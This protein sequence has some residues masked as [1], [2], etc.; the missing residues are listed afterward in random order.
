MGDGLHQA[1]LL[2]G[3]IVHPVRFAGR[4][5]HMG[6][7]ALDE[8]VKLVVFIDLEA[9]GVVNGAG[10]TIAITVLAVDGLI[11]NREQFAQSGLATRVANGERLYAV[12]E[13]LEHASHDG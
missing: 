8:A 6:A 1:A 2:V 4:D 9:L 7:P 12:D 11:D 3:D 10:L 13:R 5:K